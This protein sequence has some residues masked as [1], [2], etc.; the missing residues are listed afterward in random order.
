MSRHL[1]GGTL[2]ELDERY[3]A[4]LAD[5]Q[6]TEMDWEVGNLSEADYVALR[7]RYRLRAAQTLREMDVRQAL[8]EAVRTEVQRAAPHA[9]EPRATRS[10][11][12]PDSANR[13]STGRLFVAA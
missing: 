11:P 13:R 2:I 8:Q 6:D 3:R 12:T 7:E 9:G 1:A 10:V 5:L 4:A